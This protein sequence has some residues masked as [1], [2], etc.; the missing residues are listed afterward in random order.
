[1]AKEEPSYINLTQSVADLLDAANERIA[2]LEAEVLVWKR[3]WKDKDRELLA[4]QASFRCKHC[5][6]TGITLLRMPIH[7]EQDEVFQGRCG[8]CNGTGIDPV[9]SS[10]NVKSPPG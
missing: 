4:L 2:E 5:G 3:H 8:P 7:G 6:G 9:A 10:R 1:L